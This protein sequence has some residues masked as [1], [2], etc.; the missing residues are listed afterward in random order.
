MGQDSHRFGMVMT[1]HGMA[2]VET[3]V[4][5]SELPFTT[6]ERFTSAQLGNMRLHQAAA[7]NTDA[8]VS[9]H[10]GCMTHLRRLQS[11]HDDLTAMRHPD[12]T[13]H[14]KARA[15]IKLMYFALLRLMDNAKVETAMLVENWKQ[16][17]TGGAPLHPAQGPRGKDYISGPKV[18]GYILR[19][20]QE[21]TI[22]FLMMAVARR[23][24]L[25]RALEADVSARRQRL[26]QAIEEDA[27]RLEQITGSRA[28]DWRPLR[29]RL[30]RRTGT[31][32]ELADI[33]A[34]L[35]AMLARQQEQQ[36][37]PARAAQE[38]EMTTGRMTANAGH[39]ER[40]ARQPDTE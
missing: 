8:N 29:G 21:S 28:E 12:H 4:E 6:F 2:L 5:I 23:Q 30:R 20:M 1:M 33:A 25:N 24:Q 40:A 31:V 15:Q 37:P 19:Y 7:T 26:T 17:A 27:A 14:S 34:E 22:I 3:D 39:G 35:A 36:P 9:T 10:K 13:D 38:E 11:I 16:Q 18:E 32:N